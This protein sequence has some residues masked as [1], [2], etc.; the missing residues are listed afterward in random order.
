MNKSRT[1]K[2]QSP[3]WVWG[4]RV[5]WLGLAGLIL[6]GLGEALVRSNPSWLSVAWQLRLHEQTRSHLIVA[7]EAVGFLLQP[8]QH[9]AVRNR[10]HDYLR[11]TDSNGFPNREPW[12][13]QAD[14]VFLGDSLITGEGVGIEAQF[15]TL[16]DQQLPE[17]RVVN[18][19]IPGAGPERQYHTYRRFGESL[20][21]SWVVACW[22]IVSD[23]DND[24]HFHGWVEESVGMDYNQFR[25]SYSR[26]LNPQSRF[27]P[28]RLFKRSALLDLGRE[29]V[30]G[31]VGRTEEGNYRR[32]FPDGSEM[33]FDARK[34]PWVT[35]PLSPTDRRMQRAFDS[36]DRL[37]QAVQAQG[38]SVLL[39][40][41]P[42]KEELF[43]PAP[44]A[45]N[46]L[47][48]VR[49]HLQAHP[50]PV[51]DVYTALRDNATSQPPF[52]SRDSHLN[53]LGNHI[54][55]DQFLAWWRSREGNRN[56]NR[57]FGAG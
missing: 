46:A 9:R 51:L 33:L 23:F 53:H 20:G 40:L 36:L 28:F 34:F 41:I 15:T 31:W 44:V 7:D 27:H 25:L 57:S 26:R 10:D 11:E 47:A 38:A 32:V 48:R 18:L 39:L 8:N 56:F 29:T 45:D 19:G 50:M 14:I 6:L 43:G 35:A 3:I 2:P 37:R 12:P 4:W 22:Y 49:Q 30:M 1:S 42:S 24:T 54:V 21:A 5:L 55:A 16:I 13:A 17:R 52:F